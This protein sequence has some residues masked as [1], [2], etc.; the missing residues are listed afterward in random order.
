MLKSLC[1]CLKAVNL[2]FKWRSRG[3]ICISVLSAAIEVVLY[4]LV[5]IYR[6][7]FWILFSF[8]AEP[9]GHRLHV[10]VVSSPSGLKCQM[11]APYIITGLITAL[12]ICCVVVSVA[13]HIKTVIWASM[14]IWVFIL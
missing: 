11:A 9:S 12:Y 1:C 5:M 3:G 6:Y 4:A 8:W 2:T 13:F 14:L 7:L 10:V